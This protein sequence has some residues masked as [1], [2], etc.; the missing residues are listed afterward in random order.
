VHKTYLIF[1]CLLVLSTFIGGVNMVDWSSGDKITHGKLNDMQAVTVTDVEAE[2][3]IGTIYQN[4]GDSP[5]LCIV[6]YSC[7]KTAAADHAYCQARVQSVT[8]PISVQAYGGFLGLAGTAVQR[9]YFSVSFVVPKNYYYQVYDSSDGGSSVALVA[10][11]EIE[12]NS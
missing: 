4:T 5:I 7:D 8:P 11:S 12:F 9:G 6:S 1:V 3:A 10:W 2:R